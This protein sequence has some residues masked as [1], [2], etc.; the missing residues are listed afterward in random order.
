MYFRSNEN[1]MNYSEIIDKFNDSCNDIN[2]IK[3]EIINKIKSLLT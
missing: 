2:I 3:I 1:E